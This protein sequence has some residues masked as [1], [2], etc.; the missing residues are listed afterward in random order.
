MTSVQMTMIALVLRLARVEVVS[1]PL[2]LKTMIALVLR[3]ARV[4]VVS[5]LVVITIRVVMTLLATTQL[6]EN[7]MQ[8][9]TTYGA[10]LA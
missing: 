3:L 4:E 1:R 2:V 10:L 7:V 9:V 8:S 6:M 5:R